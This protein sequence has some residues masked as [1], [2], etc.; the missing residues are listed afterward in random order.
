MKNSFHDIISQE[1]VFRSTGTKKPSQV[2]MA[3][4]SASTIGGTEEGGRPQLTG[5]HSFILCANTKA[6]RKFPITIKTIP[7]TRAEAGGFIS[8]LNPISL[9]HTLPKIGVYHKKPR[10]KFA[11]TAMMIA[12]G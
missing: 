8:V 2:K 4:C 5:F 3:A 11:T 1:T 7:F 9:A 12:T 10:T 6:I